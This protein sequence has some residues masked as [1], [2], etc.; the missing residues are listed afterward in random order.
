MPT[1]TLKALV[2]DLDDT[3]WPL[4]PLITNAEKHTHDWLAVHAPNVTKQ[5]TVEDLRTKRL[6]LVNTNPQFSYDLWALRHTALKNVLQE[7]GEQTSKA[8]EAIQVFFQARNQ[9][10]IFP[11]VFDV[12]EKMQKTHILASISN[13][14]ADLETIGISKYFK[15]SLAAHSFGCAKP[16]PR[17]FLAMAE[18]LQLEP[19]EM[20]YIGDDLRLDVQA[21]QEVGMQAVWMNRQQLDLKDSK[22]PDVKPD[23]IVKDLHELLAV[24]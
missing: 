12:L 21:A 9:V 2:F 16:D 22:Y 14:F 18:K 4:F 15:A 1:K 13:G 24:L 3:L 5:F 19:Q 11:D 20:M 17:I 6:E 8:D 10:D 23:L 7:V